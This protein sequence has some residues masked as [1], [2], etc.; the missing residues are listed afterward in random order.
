MYAAVFLVRG[1]VAGKQPRDLRGFVRDGHDTAWTKLNRSNAICFG[2]G[3][4]AH[5]PHGLLY[6][7]GGNGV[8]R[9]TDLGLTWKVLTGWRTEEILAVVPD[10]GDSRRTLRG[11]AVRRLSGARTAEKPGCSGTQASRSWYVQR[12]L[13]DPADRKTLYALVED[14]VYRSTD[15][16][17]TWVPLRSGVSLPVAFAQDPLDPRTM[18]LGSEEDGVRRSTDGGRTW[19]P[20]MISGGTPSMRYDSP[21]MRARCMRGDTAPGCGGAS[22]G[23]NAGRGCRSRW[24]ARPSRRS[25]S[26]PRTGTIGDRDPRRRRVRIH[27]SRG[28]VEVRRAPWCDRQT[29]RI[30]PMSLYRFIAAVVLIC[31]RRYGGGPG[32]HG[33]RIGRRAQSC[34]WWGQPNPQT[35]IFSTHPPI[36]SGIIRGRRTSARSAAPSARGSWTR[37][38]YRGRQRRA[39]IDR[40][41]EELAD[42]HHLE[43]DGGPLGGTRPS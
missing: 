1:S 35:G 38:V 10:P 13:L 11:D 30:L 33:L 29:D 19:D 37:P 43:D 31:R 28:A 3:Y 14:D 22:T 24:S 7:A 42:H 25:P 26:I 16:A 9:S 32:V 23:G 6:L 15:G 40:Q 41:R 4:T 36:R 18:L 27:G 8:H 20:S 39:P 21:R 2:L 5:G 17:E 34:S 12:L